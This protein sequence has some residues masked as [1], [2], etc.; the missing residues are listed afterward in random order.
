MFEIE[1]YVNIAGYSI[2]VTDPET[3]LSVLGFDHVRDRLETKLIEQ[4]EKKVKFLRGEHATKAKDERDKR[5]DLQP[6][7]R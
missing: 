2:E 4:L 1:T 7:G 3:G 5:K 6:H